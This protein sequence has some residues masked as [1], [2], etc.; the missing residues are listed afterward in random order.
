MANAFTQALLMDDPEAGSV[1]VPTCAV[2]IYYTPDPTKDPYWDKVGLLLHFDGADGSTACTDSSSYG[3]TMTRSGLPTIVTAQSKFGGSSGWFPGSGAAFIAPTFSPEVTDVTYNL[4]T[5]EFFVRFNDV[6]STRW[7]CGTD[8]AGGSGVERVLAV[9]KNAANNIVA[10]SRSAGGAITS[11]TTV[12]TGQWYHIAYVLDTLTETIYVD[13]VNVASTV[14][15]NSGYYATLAFSVGRLGSFTGSSFIGWLDEF[16]L[17][18]GVARYT[19]NF[20]VP[21]SAYPDY[22]SAPLVPRTALLLHAETTDDSSSA[23][24]K[25]LTLTGTGVL[26][27]AAYRFGTKSLF[28][29]NLNATPTTNGGYVRYHA[30]FD[31]SANDFTFDCWAYRSA[32]T[33][34]G[35]LF[36]NTNLFSLSVETTGFVTLVYNGSGGT[37]TVTTSVV[38]PTGV[39]NHVVVQRRGTDLEFALNGVLSDTTAVA[40]G[41]GSLFAAQGY[42]APYT[43]RIANLFFGRL[44][45]SD[46]TP[47]N[48]YID[49]IRITNGVARYDT[50]PFAPPTLKNCEGTV[51]YEGE[52]NGTEA[53]R[54]LACA[55]QTGTSTI[56][57]PFAL[58]AGSAATAA[59]GAPTATL[60]NA[61]VALTGG[62]ASVSVGAVVPPS[63]SVALVGAGSTMSTGTVAVPP[64]PALLSTAM[65]QLQVNVV[66]LGEVRFRFNADGTIQ[67]SVGLIPTP[68]VAFG[69]WIDT[70][71]TNYD[72]ALIAHQYYI[73][74]VTSLVNGNNPNVQ[75]TLGD[76]LSVST[77]FLATSFYNAVTPISFVVAVSPNA[78]NPRYGEA[79]YSGTHKFSLLF[80]NDAPSS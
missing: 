65:A 68:F 79:G 57:D 54:G 67:I 31:F 28:V 33:R 12:T 59:A 3:H 23:Y 29:E 44:D 72:V 25:D 18:L 73:S 69:Y 71:Q 38:F 24:Q 26:S 78:T 15:D 51:T 27:A 36:Y 61:T 66:G 52:I 17:T 4:A 20:T 16:R 30:D 50:F 55:A 2:D 62:A 77:D 11:S 46:S 49:E 8:D 40:G 37:Q 6:G 1:L 39:W 9:S 22:V 14:S 56:Q 75:Y 41:A 13:G 76:D 74:S 34:K 19:S 48:G 42:A 58:L 43:G 53:L 7:I 45:V 60:P 32:N 80:V 21:T 10:S 5:L 64:Y 35:Y 70:T 47:W 63:R